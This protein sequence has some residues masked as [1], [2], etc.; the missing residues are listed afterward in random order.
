MELVRKSDEVLLRGVVWGAVHQGQLFAITYSAPRL[1]FF[2]RGIAAV[3][4]L[5]ATARLRQ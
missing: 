2:P 4:K 3:E 5:V 1:A